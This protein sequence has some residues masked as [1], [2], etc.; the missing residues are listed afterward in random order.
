VAF[1][2]GAGIAPR[3]GAA[4]QYLSVA[5]IAPT[6]L[7]LAGADARATK[8]A[9]RA[10]RPIT[11]RSWA[12]WLRNPEARVYGA[13]D[14]IGAELFG[15]R[16]YRQGDWKLADIGDGTWRLFNIAR[17]PGETRDLSRLDPDR[18]AALAAAW[19]QYA[20][21]VGVVLPD[22]IPYRP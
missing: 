12:S 3:Q 19:E 20:E 8:I 15:S 10:V 17:D 1:I 16:A 11:G 13:D 7:D 6:L 14:G 4:T 2:S 9:G 5:D 22:T 18:K 21:R